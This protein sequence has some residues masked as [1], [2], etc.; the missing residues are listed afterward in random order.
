M[1]TTHALS[2]TSPKGEGQVFVGTCFKC[3]TTDLPAEAVSW[4]CENVAN[5]TN[6]EALIH[7]VRG[8]KP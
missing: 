3:G 5:L 6:D 1:S 4:P 7:A 2:R 8:E